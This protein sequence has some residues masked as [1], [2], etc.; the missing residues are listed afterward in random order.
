MP[1]NSISA[2]GFWRRRL[3]V[4]RRSSQARKLDPVVAHRDAGHNADFE[5][6]E[7]PSSDKAAALTH[8]AAPIP[9]DDNGQ[10]GQRIG[11]PVSNAEEAGDSNSRI[12]LSQ[13][14]LHN[15]AD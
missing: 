13:S 15:T 7:P 6:G 10:P 8:F 11:R 2:A 1:N 4:M 14:D 5:I 9:A 3:H 12:L